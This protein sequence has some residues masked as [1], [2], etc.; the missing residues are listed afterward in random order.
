MPKLRRGRRPA[1]AAEIEE[2][3][4]QSDSIN[5]SEVEEENELSV[6]P[7]KNRFHSCKIFLD[8]SAEEDSRDEDEIEAEASLS[9]TESVDSIIEFAGRRY[10]TRT[11]RFV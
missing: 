1:V 5:E 8:E 7:P 3:A 2:N 4:P 11:F 6:S 10:N 9:E